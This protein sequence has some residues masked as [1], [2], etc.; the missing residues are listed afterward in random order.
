MKKS[1]LKFLLLLLPIIAISLVGFTTMGLWNWIMP[2]LFG[3]GTL[4]FFKALGLLLLSRIILGGVYRSMH[5]R[6][7]YK[8]MRMAYV[9]SGRSCSRRAESTQSE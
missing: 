7:H 4:T 6:A 1:K 8:N 5:R 3:L 9:R 2:A